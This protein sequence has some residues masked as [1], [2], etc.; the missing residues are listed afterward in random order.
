MKISFNWLQQYIGLEIDVSKVA[1]YLTNIGLEVESIERFDVLEGGLKGVVIGKIITCDKHPNA[2]RL[3]KT[4]VDI[5]ENNL[6]NIVCGAP[7]VEVGQYVPVAT[8]GTRLYLNGDSFKIKRSKIRGE[9]SEGMICSQKELGLGDDDEGIMVLDSNAKEGVLAS[10]YFNLKDDFIFDIGLTPNRSD[11]MSHIGVA[12][13]L[14]AFMNY[15]FNTSNKICF[16]CVDDFKTD[17][18]L[19]TISVDVEDNSL[20]SRYSGVSISGVK[21]SSSPDWLQNRLRSIGLIPVNNIVD[22]TNYVLHEIG[23]PLHAFDASK[24]S[25]NKIIVRKAKSNM[26]FTTLDNVNR[27]L[28]QDDL[29]ICNDQHPMCIAGVFG[30][31]D[32]GVDHSTDNIFLESA[33]FDPITIRRTSKRHS[34]NTDASF[35]FERGVDPNITIYALKRCALL[36]KDIAGGTISS[37]IIDVYS[38]QINSSEVELNYAR[39]NKLV[40]QEINPDIV[41]SIL[42]DLEIKI[43]VEDQDK[44]ILEVPAYRSDV[45][46]EIDVIEEVLRIYGFNKVVYP[47]KMNVSM[48]QFSNI[49]SEKLNVLVSELLNN[50]GFYEVMNNSLITSSYSN[51]SS[52]YNVSLLNP[53]SQDLNVMRR[54]LFWGGLENISYNINRNNRNLKIYEFGYTYHK[55]DASYDQRSRLA[56]WATGELSFDIWNKKRCSVDFFYLKEKIALILNRLNIQD[57]SVVD[58]ICDREVEG[59]SYIY[60]DQEVVSFGRVRSDICRSFDIKQDVYYA[61][62]NFRLILELSKVRKVQYAPISK[63]P[64]VRRDLALL[65]D[66]GIL[67]KDIEKTA[68]S[69]NNNLLRSINLFDVYQGKELPKGKKSYAL[70]FILSHESKTLNEQDV[71]RVMKKL[72]ENFEIKLSAQIRSS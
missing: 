23:Q 71:D 34:L 52:E 46:R 36:I 9:V 49:R 69:I 21:V 44:L 72:I 16:P 8:V 14:Q 51:N 58:I 54:S 35:R 5:G 27:K 41:K 30:G 19:L 4:V 6:L 61:D 12:R 68:Y 39:L 56:L 24:I 60:N 53:L 70:S 3:N 63:Y 62:F 20:C 47:E 67:F 57:F 17:N 66:Q 31:L 43:M 10:E 22:A 32:A 59:T 33:Y 26:D 37:E 29:L 45:K 11:A 38:N 48:N 65:L 15:S 7:N 40:G 42:L 55:Q 50:H 2:D 64:Y 18:N 1:E 13:D 25:G 28:H